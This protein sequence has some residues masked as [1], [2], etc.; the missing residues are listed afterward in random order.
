MRALTQSTGSAGASPSA[1]GPAARAVTRPAPP[2]RLTRSG[3]SSGEQ[4][5]WAGTMNNELFAQRGG[6]RRG[7]GER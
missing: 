2:T 4:Q 5:Q 6:D 3:S 7:P 1:P